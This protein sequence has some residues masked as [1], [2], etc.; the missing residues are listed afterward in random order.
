MST[1]TING[2]KKLLYIYQNKKNSFKV[3]T[4]TTTTIRDINNF[5]AFALEPIIEL[6][7]YMKKN[8]SQ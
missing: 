7:D 8:P 5:V 4:K 6:E 2:K 3:P 1:S